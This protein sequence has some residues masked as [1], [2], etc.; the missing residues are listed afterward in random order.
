MKEVP[1][2][3]SQRLSTLLATSVVVGWIY[4]LFFV[5]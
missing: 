4:V 1:D 3:L 5:L 2:M